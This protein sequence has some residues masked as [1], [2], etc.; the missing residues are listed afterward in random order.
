MQIAGPGAGKTFGMV[1]LV[2]DTLPRISSNRFV[3]VVT[4]TNSAVDAIRSQLMKVAKPPNN[5]FIGTNHAF[6]N[7]FILEPYG[8][9]WKKVPSERHFVELDLNRMPALQ[10]EQ[11]VRNK[12]IIRSRIAQG[13]VK[14]G[15]IPFDELVRISAELIGEKRIRAAIATRLQVLFVDEFQDL[16][17]AQLKVIDEIR[18][19]GKTEIY[20]V[21]D[22]EQYISGFIYQQKHQK[23]KPYTS[24]PFFQFEQHSNVECITINRRSCK[25]IVQ[26]ANNFHGRLTQE[27]IR[28][29]TPHCGVYFLEPIASDAIMST[30]RSLAEHYEESTGEH[31]DRPHTRLV[32]AREKKIVDSFAEG[33]GLTYI[34][35]DRSRQRSVLDEVLKTITLAAGQNLRQLGE[36]QG[37]TR[38]E[39]R[40]VAIL[41]MKRIRSQEIHSGDDLLKGIEETCHIKISQEPAYKEIDGRLSKI[42]AMLSSQI[43]EKNME[44]C[45]TVHKAK[46]LEADSVLVIAKSNN[47]LAKWIMQDIPSREADKQ[48]DCRLG[49][50][51]FTRARDVL[52]IACLEKINLK[53]R[54]EL[55]QLG[56]QFYPGDEALQVALALEA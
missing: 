30:F 6:L 24:I 12:A 50:V 19:A 23:V 16:D 43:S 54:T 39:L 56:V 18:K 35:N 5:L 55:I 36:A 17:T 45:S 29:S 15:V 25:E 3:A 21:G 33:F 52:C 1:Q 22:P 7:R 10:T 11:D 51:A 32:L 42:R 13:L 26:F 4:Y 9:L 2:A 47:E 8:Q 31:L 41:L 48:D 37:M 14:S 38:L 34:S 44:L 27:W 20:V 28:G 49:Y 40:K 46:G 53:N